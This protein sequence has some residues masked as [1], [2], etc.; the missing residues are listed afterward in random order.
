MS[1]SLL[2]SP[3]GFGLGLRPPHYE[4]LLHEHRGS[5]DWLEVL[6][7][8]YLVPGGKPLH[9]LARLRE[10]TW[11]RLD[12]PSLRTAFKTFE[13]EFEEREDFTASHLEVIATARKP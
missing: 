1:T 7:E 8:N 4:A 12:D 9:Y 10:T 2:H 5:V 3:L 6:T 13:K 11:E